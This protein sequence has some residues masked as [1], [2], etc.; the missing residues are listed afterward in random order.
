M[1]ITR[2]RTLDYRILAVTITAAWGAQFV[3]AEMD[4]DLEIRRIDLEA[5]P[6]QCAPLLTALPAAGQTLQ[7]AMGGLAYALVDRLLATA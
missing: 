6:E 1:P 5:T 4:G 7:Q 3:V 2:T